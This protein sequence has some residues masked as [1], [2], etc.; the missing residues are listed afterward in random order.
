MAFGFYVS[1]GPATKDVHFRLIAYALSIKAS[2]AIAAVSYLLDTT[3]A[4][5]DTACSSFLQDRLSPHCY[6]AG[7][8]QEHTLFEGLHVKATSPVTPAS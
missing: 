5:L 6:L 3:C 2:S 4:F 7:S 1:F 8:V